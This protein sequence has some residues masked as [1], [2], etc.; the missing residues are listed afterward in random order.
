MVLAWNP[1]PK[2]GS[3]L[4]LPPLPHKQFALVFMSK[5]FLNSLLLSS[6]SIYPHLSHCS[7]LTYLFISGVFHLS[8]QQRIFYSTNLVLQLLI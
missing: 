5:L 4:C 3:S 1:A 2:L 8:F 7:L 6:L